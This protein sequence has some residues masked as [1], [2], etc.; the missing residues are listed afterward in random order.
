MRDTR[1]ILFL[2]SILGVGHATAAPDVENW[3]HVSGPYLG[4]EPP[5]NAVE[6]F[7]R[8]LISTDQSEIGS[9]FC[10]L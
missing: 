2:F 7:A 3:P 9:V 6:L 4:Q 5:G 10:V 1:V 8:N